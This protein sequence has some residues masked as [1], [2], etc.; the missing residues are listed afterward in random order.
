MKLVYIVGARPQFVKLGPLA[1]IL[2]KDFDGVIIH[3]GQHFDTNMSQTFFEDL[4]IPKPDYNLNINCGD[5][6]EQTGRMMIEVEKL[7]RLEC[8]ALALVFGDTNTTLAGSLV[9]AKLGI[10]TVHIEA[11]L[12]SFNR[13]MPEEVNR[14]VADHVSDVLFAPTKTAMENLHREGLSNRALLTGDIMVDALNDS[15]EKASRLS[16]I[17]EDKGLVGRAYILMTLHRPYN[18]DDPR[19]LLKIFS[20]LSRL[21]SRIV[22]PIHP[23]THKIVRDHKIPIPENFMA[24][25][26]VGYLDFLK[27]ES[28]ASKIVTDSGGIQKEAYILRKPCITLRPETEWVETVREGWNI[29][30]DFE[31]A[32]FVETIESFSPKEEPLGFLGKDVAITMAEEIKKISGPLMPTRKTP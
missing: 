9:C 10:P 5:H 11:G 2:N 16:S 18:V 21:A 23:R 1:K 31:S 26:P 12:R 30:V 14:V 19:K 25:E 27:L 28:G 32:D 17:L 8:P 6:G 22:F 4:E 24:I 15:L 29:L 7:L 20:G 13:T 3:T